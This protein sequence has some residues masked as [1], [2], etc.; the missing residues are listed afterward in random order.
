[1]IFY[2]SGTGNSEYAARKIS[3]ATGD[4][5][6]SIADCLKNNR[7]S[8]TLRDDERVGFVFPVYFWGV[9]TI[10]LDFIR[11]LE[12]HGYGDNYT[13]SACTHG[14]DSG[15]MPR[16]LE[17]NLVRRGIRLDAA[18]EVE[19]PDNYIL[20]MNYLTPADK[21]PGILAAAE[22]S[23]AVIAEEIKE[24]KHTDIVSGLRRWVATTFS[25]P[26]Y[27]YGRGTRKF[28]VTAECNGCG[29]CARLCPCEMIEMR[30]RLPMW[31]AGRCT[32][33][34]ACI[35]RCPKR[36]IQHGSKTENRERYVNPNAI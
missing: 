35:H 11:R 7:L 13:W 36:A 2:F 23:I 14:G 21:I 9:P 6:V 29:L 34:L 12:L 5:V 3:E 17:R 27:K 32:Q 31:K 16:M 24:R 33:C 20:L 1:M 10:V 8:F 30:K 4:E 22:G 18:F 19:M 28:R 26:L 25:Y 15:D